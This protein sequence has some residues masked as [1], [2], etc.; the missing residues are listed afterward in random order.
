MVI[1]SFDTRVELNP[2]IPTTCFPNGCTDN[3][4]SRREFPSWFCLAV[5][6][7]TRRLVG[8]LGTVPVESSM[9]GSLS[10]TSFSDPQAPDTIH[11]AVDNNTLITCL[12][13]PVILELYY[14]HAYQSSSPSLLM[15]GCVRQYTTTGPCAH[16]WTNK[17]GCS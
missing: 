13:I 1:M 3:V 7:G 14:L 2:I 11:E 6:T 16:P 4:I 12:P 10:T 8:T 5:S 9:K 17:L 15:G